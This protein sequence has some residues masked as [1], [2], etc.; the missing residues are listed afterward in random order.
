MTASYNLLF[1]C[2]CNSARSIMAEAL[3]NER[4]KGR[5]RAYSAGV[6]PGGEI[7]PLTLK[8]LEL[9]HLPTEGLRSKSWNEFS[10]PGAPRMDFVITVCENAAGA[11]CPVWPGHPTTAHWA[12]PDPACATGGEAER[13]AAF[14]DVFK[15]INRRVDL[16]TALPLDA[17]DRLTAKQAVEHIGRS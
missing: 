8:T 7:N 4:G 6:K 16:F 14:A 1:L 9:A 12:V 17:L 10:A 11:I 5:L 2:T 3:V 13:L 15:Q